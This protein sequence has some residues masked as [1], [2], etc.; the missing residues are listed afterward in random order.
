MLQPMGRLRIDSTHSCRAALEAGANPSASHRGGIS[1]LHIA[2]W[3]GHLGVV[4]CVCHH[5]W[6]RGLTRICRRALLEYRASGSNTNDKGQTPLDLAIYQA[7]RNILVYLVVWQPNRGA[8]ACCRGT[9]RL[10]HCW[11][12]PQQKCPPALC[13]LW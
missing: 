5:R 8:H 1:P 7:H 2:S 6:E 4:Q 11:R 12:S 13:P 9:L 3:R 10:P